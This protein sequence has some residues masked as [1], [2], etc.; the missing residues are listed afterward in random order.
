MEKKT[1]SVGSRTHRKRVASLMNRVIYRGDEIKEQRKYA[2]V[3]RKTRIRNQF[4]VLGWDENKEGG[5]GWWT[6]VSK[7]KHM[8]EIKQ[9]ILDI[10][11]G[12]I[13][14]Q[15]NCQRIAGAGLAA[16]IAQ[17]YPGWLKHFKSENPFLGS[18]I[19]Y[20]A[21]KE[22]FIAS[23]YGQKNFG[24]VYGRNGKKRQFTNYDALSNGLGLVNSLVSSDFDIYIPKGIGCGLGGGSWEIVYQIL[25]TVIPRAIIVEMDRKKV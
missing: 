18:C 7:G 20:K 8:K 2:F 12:V 5:L 19:F 6:V 15:V 21:N 3:V 23:I 13:C 16:Q 9:N 22:L 24:S 1:L 14:H 10:E 4:K 17:K 11:K 25:Q